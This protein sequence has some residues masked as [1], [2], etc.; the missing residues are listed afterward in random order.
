MTADG[1]P[2]AKARSDGEDRLVAADEPLA[3][4]Q[5]RCG[6]ELPGIIAIPAVLELV[7]RARRFGLKLARTVVANDGAELIIAWIEAIPRGGADAGCDIVV[8]SWKTTPLPAEDIEGQAR[9]HAAIVRDVAELT[10]RLDASQRLLTIEGDAA[11]LVEAVAMMRAGLLRPW[12]DFIAPVGGTHHR[13]PMHWRLLDGAAVMV[14]GSDRS[15]RAHLF[16]HV[17]PGGEPAGFELSLTS[18]EP[19]PLDTPSKPVV[20]AA[21]AADGSGWGTVG[22]DIAPVLRHPLARIIANAETIR[23]RLAGP[24]ADQYSDYAADIATAGQHLL[25][26][27]DDLADLE[28]VE[29]DDFTTSP[30]AIDLA[31][32]GRRAAGILGIRARERG[33]SVAVPEPDQSVPAIGEFRRVLQVLLNLIGNAV[34]YAPENTRVCVQTE[35]EGNRARILVA[36]E[37]PGLDDDQ[38]IR[39]F[40]KF[41][42]LGRSS[43]GGSGLGLYISRRL[44]RAMGGELAVRSA[45]GEGATFILELPTEAPIDVGP[46]SWSA[47]RNGIGQ[48]TILARIPG[49]RRPAD[50]LAAPR[51]PDQA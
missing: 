15:W 1:A 34:R 28:V 36:D 40:E 45:P 23:A 26:L 17:G 51:D 12:T 44:A 5:R 29:A 7:R 30:D 46:A 41:E 48:A 33:I 21:A 3:T 47:E 39:M 14:P 19:L 25:S 4:L 20:E 18:E 22:R 32:L 27:L 2:L 50:E 31:D 24:I 16:P 6:G 37:G 49:V 9:R 35:T 8:R 38:R 42:R 13:Q 43:D 10:G 11:D